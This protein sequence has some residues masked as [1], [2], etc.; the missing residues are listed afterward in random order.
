MDKKPNRND[1]CP[2]GS[3]KKYKQ[4]CWGKEL[5]ASDVSKKPLFARSITAG[6]SSAIKKTFTAKLLSST[7]EPAK[8]TQPIPDPLE[9]AF[10]NTLSRIRSEEAP[11][12]PPS[13]EIPPQKLPKDY[14]RWEPKKE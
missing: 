11:P 8:A 7:Q 9:N 12:A 3:K 5:P 4:C 10:A 2:C 6:T 1:P 14:K 13:E